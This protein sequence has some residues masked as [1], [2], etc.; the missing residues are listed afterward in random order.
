MTGSGGQDNIYDDLKA[1]VEELRKSNQELKDR[2][3][4]I[5]QETQYV[6]EED[7]LESQPLAEELWKNPIPENLKIPN[8]PSFDGKTDPLEHLMAVWTQMALIGAA[9]PLKC[10]LLSG[11][12]KD[13][14]L[15]WYMNLPNTPSQG[16]PISTKS[17]HTSSLGASMYK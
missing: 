11:T 14:T 17:S 12:F 8:L 4:G 6:E 16:T 5:E 2:M 3:A 13:A 15:Q 1:N 9:E 7:I 10:K